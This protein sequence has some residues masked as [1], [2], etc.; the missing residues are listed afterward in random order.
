MFA[1]PGHPVSSPL[2]IVGSGST[3]RIRRKSQEDIAKS[4]EHS[5]TPSKENLDLAGTSL[6]SDFK[7]SSEQDSLSIS[8]D[9][10]PSTPSS[11]RP[12]SG[13]FTGRF[14]SS[15][16]LETCELDDLDDHPFAEDLLADF[17]NPLT[18]AGAKLGRWGW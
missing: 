18:G 9:N 6:S 12:I 2:N 3:R 8:S 7:E 17:S 4:Q 1:R 13:S 14:N 11:Q 16:S 10:V 5:P 15:I